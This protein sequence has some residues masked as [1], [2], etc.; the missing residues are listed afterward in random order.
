MA[1]YQDRIIPR[2]IHFAMSQRDLLPYRNRVVPAAE[3]RV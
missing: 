1:F 2:L 3:G